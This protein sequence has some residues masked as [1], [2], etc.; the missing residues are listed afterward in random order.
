[1][2]GAG[3]P[4]RGNTAVRGRG[5]PLAR[6]TKVQV[7]VTALVGAGLMM[8]AQPW[9]AASSG[10]ASGTTADSFT[11]LH[12]DRSQVASGQEEPHT[13][14]GTVTTRQRLLARGYVTT[15]AGPGRC[16]LV[17]NLDQ[18]GAKINDVGYCGPRDQASVNLVNG[19]LV[20]VIPLTADAVEV[21]VDVTSARLPLVNGVFISGAPPGSLTEP[22][23]VNA[24][25]SG[26]RVGAWK[27]ALPLG[28][29]AG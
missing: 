24:Y 5:A 1:M 19:A 27:L 20:G 6:L 21:S 26:R 11:R 25:L 9:R 12:P 10:P 18:H 22:V 7:V 28:A 14:I 2:Q 13:L 3:S 29:R 17:E 15:A 8:Y 16:V 4:S 23:D